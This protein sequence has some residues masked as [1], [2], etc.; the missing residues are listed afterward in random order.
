[1]TDALFPLVSTLHVLAALIWVGG[2]FFA[3]M[4]LRPALMQEQPGIRLGVWSHVLPRFFKWVW[5]AILILPVTGF[6]MVYMD[7]GDFKTAGQ[8]VSIM[9]GLFWVMTGL[10]AYMFFKPYKAFKSDDDSD[11][12]EEGFKHLATIRSI[13]TINLVLGFVNVIIG[14]S[15]RF[16]G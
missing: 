8:H 12:F 7:F 13:V 6:H 10:F 5:L 4:V 15:G 2:M 11:N 16:W 1:M 3:H 9:H 14:V